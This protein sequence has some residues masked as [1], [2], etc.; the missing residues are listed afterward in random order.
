MMES[1]IARAFTK[2]PTIGVPRVDVG[3]AGMTADFGIM[4]KYLMNIYV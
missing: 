4:I 3:S 1:K 2:R